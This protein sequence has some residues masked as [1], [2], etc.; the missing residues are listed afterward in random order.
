MQIQSSNY[1]FYYEGNDPLT[2]DTKPD[3][4]SET[5]S[6][7]YDKF[8]SQVSVIYGSQKDDGS[9]DIFFKGANGVI[10]PFASLK[11]LSPNTSYNVLSAGPYPLIVPAVGGMST[12]QPSEECPS[13][14]PVITFSSPTFILENAGQNYQYLNIEVSSLEPG[15][16]YEYKLEVIKANWPVKI[17]NKAGFFTPG[18]NKENIFAY[19]LFS[20]T[21][22]V[23][24]VDKEDFFQH[25]PDPFNNEFHARNNLYA[26]IRMSVGA[27][28]LDT[29]KT[30]TDTVAIRCQNC[31]PEVEEFYPVVKF[32]ERSAL[33]MSKNCDNAPVPV[34]VDCSNF[35]K[36]KKYNYVFTIDN[37]VSRISPTTGEIGFGNGEGQLTAILNLNGVSPAI[38]K[39]TVYPSDN[40]SRVSTDFLSIEATDCQ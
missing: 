36:G 29:C 15:L 8:L 22:T 19:A 18:E 25:D 23:A 13:S 31:L 5:D 3:G 21:E 40:P 34:V 33:L 35:A 26:I 11:S 38:L 9:Q 6:A 16:K 10:D 37:G 28:S 27:I 30:V 7:N 4:L 14:V 32:N 2:L 24:D 20:P 39:I 17:M 12:T 1:Y